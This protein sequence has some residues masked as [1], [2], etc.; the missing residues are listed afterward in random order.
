M[1]AAPLPRKIQD[2]EGA[3]GKSNWGCGNIFGGT[4]PIHRG[5]AE[6]QRRKELESAET[7]EIAE[8]KTTRV[9]DE[10]RDPSVT[11]KTLHRKELLCLVLLGV[12]TVSAMNSHRRVTDEG[13]RPECYS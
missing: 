7:A 2:T 12:S 6:T 10:G 1:A 5:D 9:N 3:E 4:K 8:I 11:A 13:W